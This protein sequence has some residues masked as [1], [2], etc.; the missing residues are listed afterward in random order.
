VLIKPVRCSSAGIVSEFT[1]PGGATDHPHAIKRST[2]AGVTQ[3]Y[4]YLP[5]GQASSAKGLSIEWTP[6]GLPSL[7][8]DS[9]A[10][11]AYSYDAF[12]SRFRTV[13]TGGAGTRDVVAVAGLFEQESTANG[14][15]FTYNIPGPEGVLGQIRKSSGSP[16]EVR[17]FH[18]D[19]VGTPDTISNQTGNVVERVKFEPFGDR[20]HA[21]ALSQPMSESLVLTSSAGFT[22]HQNADR[23]KLTD[24]RGR[25]YDSAIGGFL[26][27]DPLAHSGVTGLSRTAYVRNSPVMRVDPSGFED[28]FSSCGTNCRQ[29]TFHR[30]PRA[31]ENKTEDLT[32]EAGAIPVSNDQQSS[33]RPSLTVEAPS[34][35]LGN[36][37][38]FDRQWQDSVDY[39]SFKSRHARFGG[40][41]DPNGRLDKLLSGRWLDAVLVPTEQEVWEIG[42]FI[43]GEMEASGDR[44]RD[45]IDRLWSSFVAMAGVAMLASMVVAPEEAPV[46]AVTRLESRPFAMGLTNKGLDAFANARGATTWKQ[47]PDVVNWKSGVLDKLAD[48]NTMV[49][50]NLDGVDVSQGILRAATGRGGPTDWELLSIH[51][52]PQFWDTIR[53]WEGGKVVP[54]PFQ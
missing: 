15:L 29:T 10:S 9:W 23:F 30:L 37:S 12:N 5:G 54:N 45:G 39:L 2:A 3:S 41:D 24:M 36:M 42:H 7:V 13:E 11:T 32:G 46:A 14:S 44:E 1:V 49:H 43:R 52:N 4:E 19:H 8:S 28:V 16:T 34:R 47:L 40:Q 26:S 20:R 53:F 21:W 6:F 17:F 35:E 33:I 31:A 25:V 27:P 18:V 51:Q 48:P 38:W 22:G 50:F